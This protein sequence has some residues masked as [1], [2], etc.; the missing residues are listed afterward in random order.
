MEYRGALG[1][2]DEKNAIMRSEI[3]Q[4]VENINNSGYLSGFV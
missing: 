3:E 4:K 1:S 2:N